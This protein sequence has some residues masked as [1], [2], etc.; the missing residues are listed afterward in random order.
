[1]KVKTATTETTVMFGYPEAEVNHVAATKGGLV[2]RKESDL[3]EGDLRVF[4]VGD[5]ECNTEWTSVL[6]SLR[7]R[8]NK[9]VVKMNV[10]RDYA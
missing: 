7:R 8:S 3:P 6:S 9:C 5:W 1:M 4:L 10:A 2:I